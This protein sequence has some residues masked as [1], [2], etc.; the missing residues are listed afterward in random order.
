MTSAAELLGAQAS[1]RA[2]GLRRNICFI[3][4]TMVTVLPVPGGPNIMKGA[5]VGGKAKICLMA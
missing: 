1:M 5:E 3:A 2:S 4:S